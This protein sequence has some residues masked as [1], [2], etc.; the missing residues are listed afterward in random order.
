MI[1]I[2]RVYDAPATED[3]TRFL[4]ERLWPR[5]VK[6]EVLQMVAWCKDVAPS[7]ELRRWFNHDPAKWIEFQRRYR[8]ELTNNRS[9]CKP[10]LEA[11]RQGDI[12]LLYSAR[13]TMHNSAVVLKS[14]LEDG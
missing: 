3:G 5:G 13:D 2:K 8:S 12:T 9:A 1:R 11:A 7:N 10:L 6:K 4:V 14:Y